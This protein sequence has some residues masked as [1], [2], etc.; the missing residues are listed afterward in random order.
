[1]NDNA[2]ENARRF[3]ALTLWLYRLDGNF[4]LTLI[5]IANPAG[6]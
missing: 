4:L 3:F 6:K 1:M 2:L 5:L